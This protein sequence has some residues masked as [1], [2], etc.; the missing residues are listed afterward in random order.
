[1]ANIEPGKQ[2]DINIRYFHTLAYVDGSYEFVFP[3]VVGPRFNPLE[4]LASEPVKQPGSADGVG[5]VGRGAHGIS[6][7]STEVQYLKPNERS[8]HDISLAVDIDAGVHIENLQ[9]RSHQINTQRVQ[10]NHATVSLADA[11]RI[12][13]KDFVLRYQVAG[14]ATKSAVLAHR[15]QR[16]GYFTLMLIPPQA[17]KDL[18]RQPLEMVF[19]LDTSGSM[20]GQPLEQSKAAVRYALRT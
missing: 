8:G 20:S 17:L 4:R 9:C 3:M 2:I 13:N 6:G 10:G 5:A 16:G 1:M 12:P 18:P 15:D 11:D 7:Q 19:T 14:R